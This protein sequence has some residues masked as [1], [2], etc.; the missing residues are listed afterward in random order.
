MASNLAHDFAFARTLYNSCKG[1]HLLDTPE[2]G[3]RTLTWLIPVTPN[4]TWLSGEYYEHSKR[5]LPGKL[6]PQTHDVE[7][8]KALWRRGLEL[9]AQL[10][11]TA[12]PTRTSQEVHKTY[13]FH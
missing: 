2:D 8:T 9:I 13:D 3:G 6:N 12:G 4:E 1:K 5:A 11:Q 7:L 10:P